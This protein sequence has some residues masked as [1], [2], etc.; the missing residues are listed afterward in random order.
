MGIE[1]LKNMEL[2]EHI[3]EDIAIRGFSRP[4]RIFLQHEID[5]LN[6]SL[7]EFLK[8]NQRADSWY[9]AVDPEHGENRP[10][11]TI[12]NA[13]FCRSDLSEFVANP[14]LVN[15]AKRVLHGNVSLWRTTFWI[16]EPGARRVEW[17]QDTYKDE[18]LGSFPN[19]NSW[20]ALD[21][22]NEDNC[23]WFVGKTHS[24]IIDLNVF[25]NEPY[26]NDL[27]KS[28]DLPPPPLVGDITKVALRPG[29]C[30]FF[31]GRCL[32]GSPPNKSK[33]RRAGLVVRF[34]PEGY[35]FGSKDV[36]PLSNLQRK[37]SVE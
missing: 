31:D 12:Y 5:E 3:A 23:L 27:K 11:D 35:V 21:Y 36:Q 8:N 29:E 16:K 25:K 4:V 28:P 13:H 1:D 20:I 24:E 18:G 6:S 7:G 10:V 9:S 17:H 32:H 37:T 33:N 22:A 34:I 14:N 30:V 15:V 2:L 26:L 19:L